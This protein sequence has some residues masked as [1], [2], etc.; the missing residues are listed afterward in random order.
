MKKIHITIILML[1]SIVPMVAQVAISPDCSDPDPSAILDIQSTNSGLLIP[2]MTTTQMNAIN[3]P[4]TSLI[5]FNTTE[6][7]FYYYNGTAWENFDN[8][9][10]DG[11]N[12][13]GEDQSGIS[14][15]TGRV[16]IGT[17]TPGSDAALEVTGRIWQTGT[18]HSVF[19]GES[20]GE[21]DDLSDNRNVF[22]GYQ[23]GQQNTSGYRNTVVGMQAFRQNHS[24]YNNVAIGY[25]AAY[26]MTGSWNT[27]VG[28]F[29][30]RVGNGGWINV[31]IGDSA[32][33]NNRGAYNTAVGKNAIANNQN[34]SS[35]VGIG[36][37]ALQNNDDGSYN[38][39]FG[40]LALS[41]ADNTNY[42][43]AMGYN[44][45]SNIT[46]GDHNIMIGSDVLA[47]SPTANYQLNIGNVIYGDMNAGRI[48]IGTTTPSER[49][50]VAGEMRLRATSTPSS[51]DEGQIYFDG[52]H[53]YGRTSTG[54][55]QL[56]NTTPC[57]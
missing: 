52:A 1:L 37:Y 56:D 38:T 40:Y 28:A 43:T 4:A 53:F 47:P 20:A 30:N 8:A 13:T 11:F 42:N 32:M 27:V 36:A 9:D 21:N 2:R 46:T 10:G 44:A 25:Q 14:G 17:L 35:N 22:V 34:G 54:W 26:E 3:N 49:L 16:G 41:S 39:A 51:T 57:P 31:A 33:A 29:A 19:F 5:V 23:A 6:N 12:I 45:G 7:E 15:H 55:V 24:A 50:D 48:G 18:G